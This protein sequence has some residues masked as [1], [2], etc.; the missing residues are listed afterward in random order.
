[1]KRN[2]KIAGLGVAAM[3]AAIIEHNH[4][5]LRALIDAGA[6]VTLAEMCEASEAVKGAVHPKA[7][8]LWGRVID[9]AMGD[10]VRV[11]VFAARRPIYG[12][13][14]EDARA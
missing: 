4:E 13:E 3:E 14:N 6:D 8:V 11:T 9:E 1:M 2:K 7:A 12:K 5:T 10:K